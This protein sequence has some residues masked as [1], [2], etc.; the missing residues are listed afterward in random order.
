VS[1]NVTLVTH[2]R[3]HLMREAIEEE[4]E[5][6]ADIPHVINSDSSEHVQS[7]LIGA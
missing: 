1:G 2:L 4:P 3:R 5:R 6:P 7:G